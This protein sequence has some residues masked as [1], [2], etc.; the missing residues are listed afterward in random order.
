MSPI[1]L[2]Q[3]FKML[4]NYTPSIMASQSENLNSPELLQS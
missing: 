3:S 1:F 2:S 4:G